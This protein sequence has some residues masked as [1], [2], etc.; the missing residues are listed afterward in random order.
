[1]AEVALMTVIFL[2][3]LLLLLFDLVMLENWT[4]GFVH[5]GQTFF[6]WA[7]SLAPNFFLSLALLDLNSGLYA[8]NVALYCLSYIISPF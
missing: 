6:Y 3:L 7:T 8:Y 1:M 2:L 5:A 4:Q